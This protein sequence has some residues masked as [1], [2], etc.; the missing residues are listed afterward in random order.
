MH[1][2][3][4]VYYVKFFLN[5]YKMQTFYKKKLFLTQKVNSEISKFSILGAL[6]KIIYLSV[7]A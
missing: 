6:G 1:L 7:T 4:H 3:S 5:M 2:A